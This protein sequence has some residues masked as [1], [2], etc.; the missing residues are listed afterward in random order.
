[1]KTTARVKSF[2]KQNKILLVIILL[3]LLL[4]FVGLMPNTINA[5]ESY[6]QTHSWDLVLNLIKHGDPNPHTFKY[7]SLMFYFQAIAAF[8]ILITTYFLEILNTSL[9][10][11]F[12][13]KALDFGLF[14]DEAI[15]KYSQ[16]LVS[17]GRAETAFF[18]VIT[19]VVLYLLAKKLFNKNIGL[20]SAFFLA[21]TPLHV[22]DSHYITT[23]ILSILA[24]LIALLSLVYMMDTKSWK[25]FILSGITL[26]I[27]ATIRYYPIAF[28]AYP[29]ALLFSFTKNREWFY[30]VFVS[31][32]FV[33]FGIFIGMPYLFLDPNGPTL[34]MQDLQKYALPWYNTSISN[35]I[36]SLI[37]SLSSGGKTPMPEISMLYTAPSSFRPVHASWIFFNS[38]GIIPTIASLIAIPILAFKSF[39]KFLLL[40]IIPLFNFI[41]ISSFIPASYERLTIPTLPF[42]AIFAAYF[43][44]FIYKIT[45]K[46]IVFFGLLFL[47]AMLPLY[48]STAASFA[49]GQ[50]SIQIQSAEWVGENISSGAKIGYLT[51][52]SVPSSINYGA[53]LALEPGQKLS[54]EEAREIGVDYAFINAGRL[55]YNTY[56]FFNSFFVTPQQLY[57]NSYYSLVLSEYQSRAELLEVVE[58]PWMC[59]FNR[60]YYYKLPMPLK[61]AGT[62]VKNF[63]FEGDKAE[64]DLEFWNLKNPD[65]TGMAKMALSEKIGKTGKGSLE[66]KQE[67]FNFLPA[68]MTSEKVKVES[69]KVYTFS[70]WAK[71]MDTEET[72]STIIARVDFY[73]DGEREI[74]SEIREISLLAQ[75]GSTSLFFE[76]KR[77]GDKKYIDTNLPGKTIALSPLTRLSAKWQ[78]ISVTVE[79]SKDID[80][81]VLSI[82]P[83]STVKT[84]LYVDDINFLGQ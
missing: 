66:Y 71:S 18:G 22:R 65:S 57:E 19:V 16:E 28:L 4:R 7:G 81:A 63:N 79:S 8:P 43:I 11:S 36:F 68:R 60:I 67:A 61:E 52:V 45:N 40:I 83:I 13:A 10:S 70:F 25:W 44:N 82:Q 23:D 55:D 59:D 2:V 24:V 47:T 75:E 38:F 30:K 5:D 72:N 62:I 17:V 78:K 20:L 12:T 29:F 51:M 34:M 84:T 76:K 6:V 21:I 50:K 41:Y 64:N 32:S 73:N 53:W 15:R 42:L 35:Y 54:L 39:K 77:M 33:I 58:K 9:S 80:F 49:C 74:G 14:Y 3:A 48:K 26:G 69:D 56:P 31:V 27:S 46:K 1:M 37:S